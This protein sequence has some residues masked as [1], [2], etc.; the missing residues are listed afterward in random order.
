MRV[1]KIEL[2]GLRFSDNRT[3]GGE[4]DIKILAEDIK[5]NGLINPITVKPS[6]EIINDGCKP[7]DVY[8]V[9]AGR[10]R[11]RAVTMLGWKDIPCRVLEG[12]E[13]E[14][15]DEIAGSEN[16]NRL[17]MHPLDEASIFQTLLA[18]GDT[19]QALSKRFD[20]KVNEIYQRLQLLDLVDDVKTLFRNGVISLHS[21]AMLKTLDEEG[22]RA[23]CEKFKGNKVINDYDVNSFVS[24]RQHDTLYKCIADKQCETCKTRTFFEDKSLFPELSHASDSCLNHECYLQKWIALLSEKIK[25]LKTRHKTHAETALIAYG[26]S[27]LRRILGKE[28]KIGDT[29]Y[30]LIRSAYNNPDGKPGKNSKPCFGIDL[31]SNGNLEIKAVYWKEEKQSRGQHQQ[32]ERES[33]FAPAV[34]LLGLPEESTA[35]VIKA[36]EANSNKMQYWQLNSKLQQKHF[37][38]LIEERLK[39]KPAESDVDWYLKEIAFARVGDTSKKTIKLFTGNEFSEKQIPD[40]KKLPKEKL[41][42]LLS[43]MEFSYND[44][45]D[46]GDLESDRY[47]GFLKW[48]GVTKEKIQELYR[49]D[50]SAMIPKPAAPKK[51]TEAKPAQGEK[52]AARKAATKKAAAKKPATTAGGKKK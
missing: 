48:L 14:R 12:D 37:W 30:T 52:P 46:P 31:S 9:V 22:Q 38:P 18:K 13:I 4:G 32:T 16:I 44:M 50:L 6:K 47:M 29:K 7:I 1:E 23:F 11:I 26:S 19:I 2:A 40:L 28:A 41:F 25:N 45:P 8:E 51:E 27:S 42:L 35:T 17:G 39:A 36:L 49:A 21:A 43:A 20:R 3:Y 24:Q 10:R 15:A 34:R 33:R 5:Q